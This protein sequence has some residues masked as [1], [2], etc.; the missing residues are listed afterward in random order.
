MDAHLVRVKGTWWIHSW[1]EKTA[2]DESKRDQMNAHFVRVKGPDESTRGLF[3]TLVRVKGSDKSTRGLMY[4]LVRVK[5]PD[6]SI[7]GLIDE[8]VEEWK[9][10]GGLMRAQ[11]T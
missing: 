11:G 10:K 3:D 8:R 2:P 1:S 5:G 6:K 4:T 9:G 7:R